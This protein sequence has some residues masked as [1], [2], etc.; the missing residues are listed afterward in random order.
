ML[1]NHLF[2]LLCLVCALALPVKAETVKVAVYLEPPFAEIKGD[3][4]VGDN[5]ELAKLFADGI[6]ADV[7]FLQCPFA[8][9]MSMVKSGQADMIFGI[10][11]TAAREKDYAFLSQAY[12]IQHYPLHFYTLK[13]RQLDINNYRDLQDL[14]I[15]V[16]RGGLYYDQFDQDKSLNKIAV[17]SR[18]Q[19]IDMLLKGR[20]DTFLERE[21]SVIPLISD[22]DQQANITPAKYNYDQ[23]VEVHVALSKRSFIYQYKDLLSSNLNNYL[24]NG[25]IEKIIS[26]HVAGNHNATIL[27]R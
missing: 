23:L 5:V 11:R 12:R 15:G 1:S 16:L 26:H 3:T 7:R 19:L 18:T 21:E 17:T 13:S 9:C 4:F 2:L 14:T 24:A 8:R 20:I 6:G 25:D 22:L 27:A 10:K